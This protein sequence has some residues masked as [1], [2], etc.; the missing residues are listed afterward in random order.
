VAYI[1]RFTWTF[2]RVLLV[3]ARVL[4][5]RNL[6]KVNKDK[7]DKVSSKGEATTIA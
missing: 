6:K 3:I 5:I 4:W 7:G 2:A 1:S